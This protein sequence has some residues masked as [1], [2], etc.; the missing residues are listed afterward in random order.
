MDRDSDLPRKILLFSHSL[1]KKKVGVTVDNVLDVLRGIPFINIQKRADFYLLLRVNFVSNREEMKV[2]DDLFETFWT[3]E[4]ELEPFARETTGEEEAFEE[5]EETLS[6]EYE[7]G[8][9]QIQEWAD[10]L[11]EGSE[12]KADV[13]AYSPKEIL[14][15]K[16]FGLLQEEELEKVKEFVIALSKKMARTISRRWKKGKR[17]DR[18]DLRASI[19][20]SIRYGGEIVELRM[21]EPK[22][23][24]LRLVFFC[25]VS[26]SMDIYSQ[27]FLLFMYGVQNYYPHCETFVFSTR[28]S[29]VTS[30]LKRKTFDEALSLLSGKVPDWSGGTNIGLALHQLHRSHFDLLNSRRTL[31]L[32][33]SDGWDRGDMAILD[34]E[35]R[36]LKKQVKRIIWLNPLLGSRNY[37]PL[38]KGMSIAL[39]HIDHFLPC[40]NFLSL[41]NLGHLTTKL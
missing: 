30:I 38:C 20:K 7:T 13:A 37:Q 22:I 24:P 5:G 21:K 26:G 10:E 9:L 33:F 28:L 1:R 39:P 4:E 15:E 35:M 17:G 29:H 12:E 19:R 3:P 40:H 2:F 14:R 34:L 18:I 41:R 25:D 11:D 27:F 6:P 8:Q 16:N 23:K 32:I 36:N 31:F